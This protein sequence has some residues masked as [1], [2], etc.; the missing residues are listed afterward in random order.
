VGEWALSTQF[1]VTDEFLKKWAD[2]QNLIYSQK[3]S[4]GWLVRSSALT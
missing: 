1:S 4:A 2:A 3:Q